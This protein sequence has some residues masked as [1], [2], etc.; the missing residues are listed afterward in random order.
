MAHCIL[1]RMPQASLKD[2]PILGLSPVRRS[3]QR[4]IVTAPPACASSRYDRSAVSRT[5]CLVSHMHTDWAWVCLTN[6]SLLMFTWCIRHFMGSCSSTSLRGCVGRVWLT[7]PHGRFDNR[8][9]QV[10]LTDPSGGLTTR[11]ID[12]HASICIV[13]NNMFIPP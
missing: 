9:V 11:S 12:T 7:D 10:Y 5:G 8:V 13:L 3:T 6:L 4:L 2:R 1:I